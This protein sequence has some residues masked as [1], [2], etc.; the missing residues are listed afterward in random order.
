MNPGM[1]KETFSEKCIWFYNN[2]SLNI[3]LPGDVRVMNPY[4]D[5]D[6]LRIVQLFFR[7]FYSDDH[8]RIFLFGINPGRFG[9][10]VTGITFTDPVRLERECGIP[11][12][13]EKKPE[14][15]SLFIYEMINRFGG[16]EKF[17]STCFLTAVCPLGFVKNGKNMN[18]YDDKN[19]QRSLEGFIVS[20][21]REQLG[22]G[23]NR[24]ICI[25]L[26]EGKNFDFFKM[27]NEKYCFFQ[28]I[29]PLPH[30]RF[31]M[32]YRLKRKE[33]YLQKYLDV[34]R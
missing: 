7:K 29:I 33:E 18:Y 20:S 16:T 24:D 3:L 2:L 8:P 5:P 10:G 25:C 17:F 32:Q 1:G 14:L 23:A 28:K 19:L 11:S 15:S 22:F 27:L 9:A 6:V 12:S 34:L 31:I 21:I 4:K 30:P 13:L 26:G